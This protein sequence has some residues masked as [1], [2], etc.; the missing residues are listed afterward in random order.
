MI[1][2]VEH[3]ERVLNYRVYFAPRGRLRRM[4]NPKIL[5]SDVLQNSS[6]SGKKNMR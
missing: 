2:K 3:P 4:R 5:P 6:G 1:G